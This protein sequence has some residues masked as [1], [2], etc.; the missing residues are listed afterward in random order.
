MPTDV[1]CSYYEALGATDDMS[2]DLIIEAYNRQI[3]VDPDRATY[4]L[5]CLQSIGAWRGDSG[6]VSIAQAVSYEYNIGRYADNDIPEAFNYF[7]LDYRNE[8]LSEDAIIGSFYARVG[9]SANDMEPRRQLWRIG[10]TLGS[11]KIKA[12]AEERAFISNQ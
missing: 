8:N 3:S 5:R 11:E 6:G 1:D 4:Y 7:S 9:D 10:D 12:V 2:N